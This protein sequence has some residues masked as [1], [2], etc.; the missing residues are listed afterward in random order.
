MRND[1][2]L[3]IEDDRDIL[4]ANRQML[5]LEGYRVVTAMSAEAGWEAAQKEH[6]DLIL[7]DILLPDGN[8]LDL[9]RRLRSSSSVR[10]LFLSALNTKRDVI[11]GLR[12][13][14]DDYLAK[15]YMTEE[16]LLRIEALLR[17]N[18]N[19]LPQEAECSGPIEWHMTSNTAYIN[20]ED[21]LLKPMEYTVLRLL[22]ANSGRYTS[23]EE[24][25]RA[26]WGNDPNNDVR[27]V[28]NHIY[29]LR[30]KL[31]P[32]GI[33]IESKRGLGYKIVF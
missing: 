26:A 22:C 11:E 5:E 13:G 32:Y 7:L 30:V 25:Y 1:K 20:G 17:R 6:P 19:P 18:V 15:P 27:P 9:C 24:I 31:K 29:C 21:L 8:G 33:G 2:I 16:L 28:H 3:I 10:I 4:S 14:G 12:R 23:A